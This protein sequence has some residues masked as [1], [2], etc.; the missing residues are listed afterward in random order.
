MSRAEYMAEYRKR[1]LEDAFVDKR[2]KM[3]DIQDHCLNCNTL[4]PKRVRM[5]T[6]RKFCHNDKCQHEYARKTAIE[7]GIAGNGS[8]KRY[9]IENRGYKCE[10]CGIENWLNK[11]IALE[12][13]HIDGNA[14]N[15]GLNNVKL[16]CPNCHSQTDNHRVKNVGKGRKSRGLEPK[17]FYPRLS[18]LLHP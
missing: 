1:K 16:L 7:N 10:E 17:P 12:L 15:N 11:R 5:K 9:L 8:T 13:H 3:K 6:V 14:N 4:L 18:G 2:I